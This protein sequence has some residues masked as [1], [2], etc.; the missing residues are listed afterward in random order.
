MENETVGTT[1]QATKKIADEFASWAMT[2]SQFEA[3]NEVR[4]GFDQ[5]LTIIS[6]RIPPENGRYLALVKTKLE[7]A[8]FFA[9]KG[10]AKP[11]T[12]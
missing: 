10:I 2:P 9:V 12:T 7:E 4:Y 8:S 5:L 6:N 11:T 1:G 3:M